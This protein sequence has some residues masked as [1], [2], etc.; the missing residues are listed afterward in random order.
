VTAVLSTAPTAHADPDEASSTAR[1]RATLSLARAESVRLLRHPATAVTAVLFVAAWGVG[2]V[3]GDFGARF[4]VLPDVDSATH[5]PALLLL[6]VGALLAANLTVLRPTRDRT[7]EAFGLLSLPE[8]HRTAA[9]LLAV[10]SLGLLAAVL[11]AVRIG[12]LLTL[13]DAAGRPNPYEIATVPMLTLV[14]GALGVLLGRLVRAAVFAPLAVAGAGAALLVWTMLGRVTTGSDRPSPLRWLQPIALGDGA[15]MPLPGDLVSR[16]AGRHL[17]YLA[18]IGL[19]L[20]LAALIRSGARGPR[21][22]VA[23]SAALALTVGAGVAQTRPPD[24]R[25][26]DARAAATERPAA[27]QDC[28]RLAGGTYCAFPD[29]ADW[30]DDWDRVT[31]AVLRRVPPGQAPGPLYFRQRVFAAGAER[32]AGVHEAGG[33]APLDAWRADDLAAGTPD[34]VALPTWWNPAAQVD[35]AGA[36]AYRAIGG[37]VPADGPLCGGRAVLVAWLVGQVGPE[38]SARV[39]DLA[40]DSRGLSLAIDTSAG[41]F[42]SLFLDRAEL[43]VAAKLLDR[44]ADGVAAAVAAAW[45]ELRDPRTRTERAAELLGVPGVPPED[46]QVA[47]C[48]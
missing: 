27:R 28:Q 34:P 11:E 16:P 39:R 31:L 9:H 21:L 37:Q 42:S 36:L 13:P 48:V 22:I 24:Q 8:R 10:L 41:F 47:R 7:A 38:T 32:L 15:P 23:V 20:A 35:L 45:T 46:R 4:P 25:L 30:A 19:I 5:I 33:L 12:Y 3:F 26:L 6:A 14:G 1:R 44:S 40:A 2:Q 17:A 18:G 29:F 43:A